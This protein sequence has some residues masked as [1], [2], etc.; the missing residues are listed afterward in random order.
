MLCLKLDP[1][2]DGWHDQHERR[3]GPAASKW[4]GVKSGWG[5][6]AGKG[7]CYD[8]GWQAVDPK[9]RRIC[10][11]GPGYADGDVGWDQ[12]EKRWHDHHAKRPNLYA[13]GRR[14]GDVGWGRDAEVEMTPPN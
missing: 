1:T 2:E 5:T 9:G 6:I 7:S 8:E 12:G 4:A 3:H 10:D 14:E 13:E 11:P